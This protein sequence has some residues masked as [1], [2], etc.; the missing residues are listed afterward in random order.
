MIPSVNKG[1]FIY[2]AELNQRSN[3]HI[4]DEIELTFKNGGAPLE[5]ERY[6]ATEV[7]LY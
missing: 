6:S 4:K 1:V 2:D 5:K 7:E 3:V